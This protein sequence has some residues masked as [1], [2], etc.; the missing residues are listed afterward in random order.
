MRSLSLKK[1]EGH[2]YDLYE[3]ISSSLNTVTEISGY[4]EHEGFKTFKEGLADGLEEAGKISIDEKSKLIG[5]SDFEEIRD[6]LW[7]RFFAVDY[8]KARRVHGW[9]PDYF[10]YLQGSVDAKFIS[11]IAEKARKKYADNK[12]EISRIKRD[13]QREEKY[14]K[15][16]QLLEST[17]FTAEGIIAV[18]N[19][20]EARRSFQKGMETLNTM[21]I[22]GAEYYVIWDL[23]GDN[24]S[25]L[26]LVAEHLK[27]EIGFLET[28]LDSIDADLFDD[29]RENLKI[30]RDRLDVL[31]VLT[32]HEYYK[33]LLENSQYSRDM[34]MLPY[35]SK[36]SSDNHI[37]IR[38][39][40]QSIANNQVGI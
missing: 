37:K 17:G 27:Q 23:W 32:P 16:N 28:V 2:S 26:E 6:F 21:D 19:S 15:E 24:L 38:D 25:D 4:K 8:Y 29:V 35:F 33:K 31:R 34:A 10:K 11:N 14:R 9:T 22:W 5:L 7:K 20:D 13:L 40:I 36:P 18:T 12:T 1:R 39:D 30:A 3:V